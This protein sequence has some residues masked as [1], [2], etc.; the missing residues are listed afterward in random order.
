MFSED[1]GEATLFLSDGKTVRRQIYVAKDSAEVIKERRPDI[2]APDDLMYNV[3]LLAKLMPRPT[4]STKQQNT[5]APQMV[6][7]AGMTQPP[8]TFGADNFLGKSQSFW[9]WIKGLLPL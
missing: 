3:S 2:L 8:G 5:L 9:G 7:A 4:E 6:P 1:S